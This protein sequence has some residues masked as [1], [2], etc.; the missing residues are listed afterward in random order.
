MELA[1]IQNQFGT[2][3]MVDPV[4]QS[5]IAAAT[6]IGMPSETTL[7]KWFIFCPGYID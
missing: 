7:A 3:R 1:G 2:T 5:A 4:F 6:P